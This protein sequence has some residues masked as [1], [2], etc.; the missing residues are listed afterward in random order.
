[1]FEY[2]KDWI[3]SKEDP[4]NPPDPLRP[5]SYS[6]ESGQLFGLRTIS[7]TILVAVFLCLA[8]ALYNIY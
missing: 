5:D 1:M 3:S 8:G 7:M 4:D 6:L 2:L